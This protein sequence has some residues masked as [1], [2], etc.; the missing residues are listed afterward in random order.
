MKNGL[1][2]EHNH[3]WENMMPIVLGGGHTWCVTFLPKTSKSSYC[4][5]ESENFFKNSNLNNNIFMM[6]IKKLDQI[7]LFL[8]TSNMLLTIYDS[9]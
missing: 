4:Q 7:I 8:T 9:T 3:F 2:W 1:T 6:E 5:Q